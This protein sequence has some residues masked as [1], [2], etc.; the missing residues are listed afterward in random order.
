MFELAA[1]GN[2]A[3]IVEINDPDADPA[4]LEILLDTAIHTA[5]EQGN[6]L[7]E[8]RARKALVALDTE[9]NVRAARLA[10]LRD[11]VRSFT[12]GFDIPD[13]KHAAELTN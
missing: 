12:D 10:H 13:L 3:K 11:V 9:Q 4:A 6:R 5:G 8:L 7:A 1:S 2:L